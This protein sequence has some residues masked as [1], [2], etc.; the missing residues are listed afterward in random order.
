MPNAQRAASKRNG[1]AH[2]HGHAA[3]AHLPPYTPAADANTYRDLLIFEERLKQNAARLEARKNK[4]ESLLAVFVG[5]IV[6]LSYHVFIDRKESVPLHYFILSLLLI[7]LTTLFLFFASGMHAERIRAANKFVPQANRS[8]R[9][10][11]M[12]LNTRVDPRRRSPWPLSYLWPSSQSPSPS[13]ASSSTTQRSKPPPAAAASGAAAGGGGGGARTTHRRSAIPPIPPS[14]NPR[15]ELIFSTKV[16]SDFRDGYERYRAAFERRRSEKMLAKRRR[17]WKRWIDW[18]LALALAPFQ[19]RSAAPRT[20]QP[21]ASPSTSASA[22]PPAAAAAH[23]HGRSSSAHDGEQGLD[24][25]GGGGTTA[26]QRGG[27]TAVDSA[28]SSIDSAQGDDVHRPQAADTADA[29]PSAVPRSQ[30]EQHDQ[31]DRDAQE[32]ERQ[33]DPGTSTRPAPAAV[34]AAAA[35]AANE[36]QPQL[37]PGWIKV[38]RSSARPR[39]GRSDS[40]SP[41]SPSSAAP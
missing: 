40:A 4:Y 16:S 3:T 32:V 30:N 34:A 33:L 15:G 19:S 35:A 37:G 5:F 29:E 20:T 22:A 39:I 21:A 7:C 14:Q 18:F 17:S 24:G 25:G 10:F 12:Y 1:N 28:R 8:L 41:S 6:F 13:S 11:N 26:E 38:Q 23:A 31:D 9:S 2:G 27:S 36:E